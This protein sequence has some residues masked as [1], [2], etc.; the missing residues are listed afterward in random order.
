M[1]TGIYL[2]QVGFGTWLKH[3]FIPAPGYSWDMWIGNW[4]AAGFFFGTLD[5]A[6]L[7]SSEDGVTWIERPQP[8]NNASIQ[9]LAYDTVRGM[10]IMA[11]GP[12]GSDGLILTSLAAPLG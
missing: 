4:I 5:Q 6:P 2:D 11:G 12:T 8:N 10:W 7:I 9:A 1:E 3:V